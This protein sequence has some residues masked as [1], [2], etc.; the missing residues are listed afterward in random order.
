MNIQNYKLTPEQYAALYKAQQLGVRFDCW[1]IAPGE[2]IMT[3]VPLVD[4]KAICK[5]DSQPF[6]AAALDDFIK[7][8]HAM[9]IDDC[10]ICKT[11]S[12]G[13]ISVLHRLDINNNNGV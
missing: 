4:E 13:D 7:T 11:D 2:R 8:N 10:A 1:L 12:R 5:L 9:R 3:Q 6:R